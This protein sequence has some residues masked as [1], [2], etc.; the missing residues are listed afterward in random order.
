MRP[1]AHARERA[2]SARAFGGGGLRGL[3]AACSM[4]RP[5]RLGWLMRSRCVLCVDMGAMLDA[6]RRRRD[7]ADP[8]PPPLGL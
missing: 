8:G 2:S 5:E 3:D 7:V 1:I 4:G 6:S